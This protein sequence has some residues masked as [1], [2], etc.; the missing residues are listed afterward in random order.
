MPWNNTVVDSQILAV[1]AALVPS[2]PQGEVV[3]FGGDEHWSA[4]QES[5]GGDKWKKTRLYDVA[6]HGLVGG[7]IPSPDSDVFC[8]HH[9]FAA[10]GR[11][12]IGGGTWKWPSTAD[13]HGHGLDF[14]GHRRC[15]L[16]NPRER[17]WVEVASLNRNPDQP[18]EEESGGRWYPGLVTLGNGD[19]LAT[20]GHAAQQDTR[21]RNTLPERYNQAANTWVLLPKKMAEPHPPNGNRYLFFARAFTLPDGKV[22]FATPMPVDFATAPSGQ[23][24]P[25]FS[26]RYDPATGDY[27]GHKIP[28]PGFGGYLDW[29]RPAVLLPLLPQESYRP[30]VLFCGDTGAVRI[31]LGDPN[32]EWQATGG[33]DASVSSLTRVYSN[34]VVLPTGKVC[35]VGGMN[36]VG[37][38]LSGVAEV[39]VNKAE[40]YDPGIDWATGSYTPGT[41]TWS[42]DA[43]EAA[44]NRN[45]HSTALLLPN[46]KVWVAGGN[47]QGQ[48][49]D[50]NSVGVKK[51]ELYEPD[52]IAVGG[53]MQITAPS[54]VAYGQ[55]F[56][57]GV[58]RP[59]T[60]VGR[61]AL[62]RAGSVTHSTNNDQ[63]YVGLAIT[64][65]SGN[66]LTV[67][68]PPNGNVAPPGYYMLW[69]VDTNGNPCQLARFV[70]LA[71]VGCSVFTDRST[72]SEEEIAS[73]GGGGQAT[74]NNAIYV[75]FDGF[76]DAE[77]SGAPTFT[78]TWADT[79]TPVAASELTLVPAGRLLE[80]GATTPDVPQRISFPFHVRFGGAA[81]FGSVVDERQV[82][83]TFTL[84]VHSCSETIDLT[85][86]PNPYMTDIDPA[87]NNP[88]WLSTDVRVFAMPGLV[89]RN[90]IVQGNDWDDGRP[91]IKSILDLF[92]ST[93]E[94]A[95][96]PFLSIPSDPNAAP[97]LLWPNVFGIRLFNYA[98][99]KVRYRATTTVAQRVKVFFRL[100]NTVGTALSYD[101]QT[102]YR[103]S[104]AGPNTVPLLGRVGGELV[105]IPFFVSERVETVQGRPNALSMRD[106]PL[107]SIYEIKDIT[108]TPGTEVTM[109]FGCWLDFNRTRERYPRSPGNDDGPWP[110][111]AADSIQELV[112]GRH[113][114]LVAEVY[115]EPDTT[116]PQETPSTSD[117][118][119]QRNVAILFSDNPGSP[120]SHTVTHT[121]EVKPSSLPK[122]PPEGVPE[123]VPLAVAPTGPTIAAFGE[124]KRRFRPDELFFRWYNLP[125]DTEV[126]L[127]F[128][129][130]DTRDIMRLAA[131][132]LSPVA[133]TAVD[134][135]T[136]SFRVEDAT[137]LPIPGG[138]TVNIPALLSVRLPDTVV[139]GQEYRVSVQ[140][141]D[142]P[143]Q[144]VIGAFELAI[145]VGKASGILEDEER[146]LSVMKHIATKIPTWDRWYPIFQQYVHGLGVK[147]DALGGDSSS[148]HPNPDGSGNPY[149]PPREQPPG[150]GGLSG[151]GHCLEAWA[152]S[153]VLTLALVLLGVV[154]S[155]GARGAI[156]AVG[157][158]LLALLVRS[159]SV[160][161]CGRLRCALLDHVLL[162]SAVAA[163][164]LAI[165]LAADVEADFLPE[166][167]AIAAA[168]AALAAL[169]SFALRCRG[170]CCDEVEPDCEPAGGAKAAA[171]L[172]TRRIP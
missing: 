82:R 150:G 29:S 74:I 78:L 96:H 152:V 123:A 140:Q 59:A 4:Q 137:Y 65:R 154:E 99:A 103:H 113:Q 23:D 147:V 133:F 153:L 90:G 110:Q 31:D 124:G 112:R 144:Q 21:H 98:V 91:F 148:V 62:I 54:F 143:S 127:F 130:V 52:Y 115:F 138:R 70:R 45:Y 18:D 69:A 3:L 27:L 22:F 135:H 165:L 79:S 125:T 11:L 56:E 83:V 14:L 34:A 117:N 41:G 64:Q 128:S 48:S 146:T 172:T 2:G 94:S 122:L 169:G 171:E 149:V 55:A 42:V 87:V 84:G 160:R 32:G 155:A 142:G 102:T 164:V 111:A 131:L 20:F 28:Q 57:I 73:L 151:L 163:G 89:T 158:V 53:R 9:A 30:R 95:S 156:A 35:L 15:W 47:V 136:I 7:T 72:F 114:C 51:I 67:T 37:D 92:N 139:Y 126:T 134:K 24:G 88:G 132:R 166:A 40:L 43:D 104:D 118:L 50:P 167:T 86:S 13:A 105:S 58:D 60:S 119:A 68:A 10:D 17:K 168:I 76:L 85:K 81:A 97:L 77:L 71:H 38:A 162:G 61:V 161:C 75:Y 46:G 5:Q 19:V 107:D 108:P 6:S 101:K 8:S 170:G 145:P 116:D 129:D 44:H 1:H 39:P 36:V 12:L 93:P 120:E 49:G 16:Y 121:L 33:R 106:Q 26:T 109:Y 66:T 100:F 159:W 80:T 25:Y 63:R 157:L 141:I